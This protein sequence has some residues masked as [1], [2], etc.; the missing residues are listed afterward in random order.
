[1]ATPT[2]TANNNP[3]SM[4]LFHCAAQGVYVPL[5]VASDVQ[6]VTAPQL[7]LVAPTP[8]P[9][10]GPPTAQPLANLLQQWLCTNLTIHV[11][12]AQQGVGNLSPSHLQQHPY[13]APGMAQC[14]MVELPEL[15]DLA[16][17]VEARLCP[18][19]TSM[20]AV[21]AQACTCACSCANN[22]YTHHQ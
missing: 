13:A 7:E 20:S 22:R 9:P 16:S 19:E 21:V 11:Q 4:A 14:A 3:A 17:L 6:R 5:P 15:P 1:M 2:P 12:T 10:R 8:C 18:T